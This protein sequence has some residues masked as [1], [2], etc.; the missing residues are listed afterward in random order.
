[1][2]WEIRRES[3]NG[4][5]RVSV[6]VV[7]GFVRNER[8]INRERSVAPRGA[9]HHT[10]TCRYCRI[11]PRPGITH[12]IVRLSIDAGSI[13]PRGKGSTR[14]LTWTPTQT[15]V[16]TKCLLVSFYFSLL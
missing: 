9:L 10:V 4:E 7:V 1:M 2:D 14:L 5:L 8:D 6:V 3:E 11:A 15:Q 13:V 12:V 16:S